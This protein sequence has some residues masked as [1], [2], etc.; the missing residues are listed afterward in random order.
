MHDTMQGERCGEVLR[1]TLTNEECLQVKSG[2]VLGGRVNPV[3]PDA[4]IEVR[5]LSDYYQPLSGE[6]ER[7]GAAGKAIAEV[8]ANE[9]LC[10]YVP[11]GCVETVLYPNTTIPPERIISPCAGAD[12]L[13]HFKTHVAPA[14]IQVVFEGSLEVIDVTAGYFQ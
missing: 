1:V 11:D 5:K 10:L 8:F 7:R 4:K 14:G 2:F 12:Y 3:F 13:E 6:P 9:D